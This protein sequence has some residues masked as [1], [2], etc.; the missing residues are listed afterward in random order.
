MITD[1]INIDDCIGNTLDLH[2]LRH[3]DVET[4]LESWLIMEYNKSNF[5]FNI[6]KRKLHF[7]RPSIS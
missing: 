5:P 1:D 7:Y 6:L 3:S 2:G 4:N